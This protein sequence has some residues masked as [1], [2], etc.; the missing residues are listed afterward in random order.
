MGS[1]TLYRGNFTGSE[2]LNKINE[3]QQLFP[4]VTVGTADSWNKWADGTGDDV[5]RGGVKLILANAFSYW[6]A[7]PIDNG[8]ATYFDDVMQA[9]AHIQ[10]VSGSVDAVHVMNGETGWPTD[11]GSSYGPA[12]ASTD[13]AAKF[14]KSGVCG[15][16][17]WGMDLFFFEAFDE[18][19]KPDSVGQD[20]KPADE[21]HWGAYTVDG[22]AK[23]DMSC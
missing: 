2:L 7:Q 11:G 19:G 23:F 12:Q 8:T 9:L 22:K 13:D 10:D 20:G 21:K 5:I 4:K 16:K 3:V 6:Q 15:M 17:A 14:W 18:P 1:E